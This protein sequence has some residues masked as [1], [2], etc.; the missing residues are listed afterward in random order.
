M[1][2]GKSE[3][4]TFQAVQKGG[5]NVSLDFPIKKRMSLN[6]HFGLRSLFGVSSCPNLEK[7]ASSQRTSPGVGPD[8]AS[9]APDLAGRV[10]HC[11]YAL[12][13]RIQQGLEFTL[14]YNL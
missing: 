2:E 9:A 6:F 10:S 14:I 13:R 11:R 1:F 12:A 8:S 3:Y 5:G 4:A 7:R